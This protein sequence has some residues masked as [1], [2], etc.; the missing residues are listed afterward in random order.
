VDLVLAVAGNGDYPPRAV[1]LT[2]AAL[3]VATIVG[4][5]LASRGRRSGVWTV[6]VARGL[7]AV[8]ALPAFAIGDVPPAGVAAAAAVVV[9]TAIVLI[10]LALSL[11][12]PALSSP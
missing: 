8:G 11:R 10:L 7:S 1:T 12:R 4:I 5:V 2:G 6:I 9:I 3:A